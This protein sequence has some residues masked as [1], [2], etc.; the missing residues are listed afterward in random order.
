MREKVCEE[1][2]DPGGVLL[3]ILSHEKTTERLYFLVAVEKSEKKYK[4]DK[5][6]LKILRLCGTVQG[7]RDPMSFLFVRMYNITLS[8]YLDN[9]GVPSPTARET[10][11]IYGCNTLMD[12]AA[13]AYI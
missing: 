4:R 7:H 13:V 1:H 8:D 10:K 6:I 12:R 2:F 5:Y 9:I 3:Y 11:C